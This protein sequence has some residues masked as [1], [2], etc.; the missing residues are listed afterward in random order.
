MSNDNNVTS[1]QNLEEQILCDCIQNWAD[2]VEAPYGRK[3]NGDPYL[4][5]P[6]SPCPFTNYDI[7]LDEL[8]ERLGRM[9]LTPRK[10]MDRPNNFLL[11]LS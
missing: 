9:R 8:N 6:N 4:V 11:S 1:E 5:D 10:G 2:E 3:P 7:P